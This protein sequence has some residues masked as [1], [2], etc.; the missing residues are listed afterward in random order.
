MNT[1]RVGLG[2]VVLGVG[3]W[4]DVATAEE[5]G[6]PKSCVE[7]QSVQPQT[8]W[9]DIYSSRD[10]VLFR[11]DFGSR[12]GA[13]GDATSFVA[14]DTD[15]GKLLAR[16]Q[17]PSKLIMNWQLSPDGKMLAVPVFGHGKVIQL[18]EVGENDSRG[19]PHL[20]LITELKRRNV[21]P[22]ERP[23]SFSP[24][25]VGLMAWTPDSKTLIAGYAKAP[26]VYAGQ[27][28]FWS[29]TDKPSV[30]SDSPLDVPEPKSWKPWAKLDFDAPLTFA[31]SPDDRTLA[32]VESWPRHGQGQLFDLQTAAPREKFQIDHVLKGG[33]QNYLL[34]FSPDSKTLVVYGGGERYFKL[35]DTTSLKPRV[36]LIR[37]DFTDIMGDSHRHAFTSDS[38]WLLTRNNP[39][40]KDVTRRQG[41]VVQV[42]D[43]QTGDVRREVS[44]PEQLGLFYSMSEL[45]DQRVLLRFHSRKGHRHFL[46]H[47]DDLLRYAVEHGSPPK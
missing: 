17:L 31:V 46:W 4:N 15:T 32:V 37:P 19:V 34:H 44:F 1:F 5:L 42:R 21:P 47:T 43:A 20:R 35:W 13:N 9:D 25:Y 41:G 45:Q 7:L 38:R 39:R 28:L 14:W 12:A 3:V 23:D 30:D 18:W 22:E 33:T 8:L 10:S 2:I 27:I 26:K 6:F 36:D 16:R 29:F 24:Q 11:L 40:N